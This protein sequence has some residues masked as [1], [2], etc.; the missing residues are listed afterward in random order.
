MRAGLGVRARDWPCGVSWVGD[1]G[2]KEVRE[3]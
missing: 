1:A 2:D 3:R